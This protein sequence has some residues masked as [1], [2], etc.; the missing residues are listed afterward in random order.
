VMR[1]GI[2]LWIRNTF[3]PDEPGTKITPSGPSRA[4]GV[5]AITAIGDAVLIT[6]G[7][8]ALA[9]LPD[10]LGRTCRTTA[11]IRAE[12]LLISQSSSQND[13]CLVISAALAKGTVEALRHEFAH[14]LAREQTEH[15]HTDAT[16]A[17]VTVVGQGMRGM[18]RFIGRTF[19]A[20]DRE[21]IDIVAIAQGAT[22]CTISFV[23][24]K[25]DMQAALISIHREFQLGQASDVMS[26]RKAP[27][28]CYENL[29]T[30]RSGD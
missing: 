27:Y 13:L 28:P 11:A 7:G 18:A 9:G 26:E 1:C 16:V 5:T 14:E 30:S 2:P 21:N 19:G 6:L 15:I 3:S 24:A 12:V 4:P 22:E 20:T 23:I 25:K 8:P 29:Q 17:I 10:V